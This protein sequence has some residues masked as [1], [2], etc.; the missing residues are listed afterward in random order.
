MNTIKISK[1]LGI[2]S[3]VLIIA[4]IAYYFFY[5]P[6]T[7]VLLICLLLI[8]IIRMIASGIKANFYEKHYSKLKEDN[9][10]MQRRI[11]ELLSS[12]NDKGIK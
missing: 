11:D 5:H 8:C 6:K 1:L 4:L 7:E 3:Y 2:L 10:F 9:E 12:D